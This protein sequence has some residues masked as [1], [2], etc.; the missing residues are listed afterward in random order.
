LSV[1]SNENLQIEYNNS[2]NTNRLQPFR[3]EYKT[4]LQTVDLNTQIRLTTNDCNYDNEL[5][6]DCWQH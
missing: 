6:I 5:M 4:K 3:V 1:W 2:I